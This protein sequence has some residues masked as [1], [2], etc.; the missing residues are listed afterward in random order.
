MIWTDGSIVTCLQEGLVPRLNGFYVF[1]CSKEKV[2]EDIIEVCLWLISSTGGSSEPAEENRGR[3]KDQ[4][5]A[6]PARR[7]PVL[8][9]VQDYGS[10]RSSGDQL[11]ANVI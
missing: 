5:P 8:Q 3:G 9:E 6:S 4:L 10:C 11:K 2:K 7:P 1:T